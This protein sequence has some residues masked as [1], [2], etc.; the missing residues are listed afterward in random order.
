MDEEELRGELPVVDGIDEALGFERRLPDPAHV[1]GVE[2]ERLVDLADSGVEAR[3][4]WIGA[5][6][7]GT[8]NQTAAPWNRSPLPRKKHE[9][10][11]KRMKKLLLRKMK[12]G[13]DGPKKQ[14][15]SNGSG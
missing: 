2:H 10:R 4:A 1:S 7:A 13:Q 9:W 15:R 8:S 11:K 5:Y 3:A 14:S 12:A 6:E